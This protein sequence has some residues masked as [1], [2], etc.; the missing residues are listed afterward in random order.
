MA[1]EESFPCDGRRRAAADQKRPGSGPGTG[2]TDMSALVQDRYGRRTPPGRRRLLAALGGV[3]LTAA[4]AFIAWVTLAQGPSLTWEE[5]GYDVISD[6]RAEVT[7]DVSFGGT[8][9][10]T[11][12]FGADRPTA[13]CTVQALN[14][15]RTEVG[16]QDVRVQPGNG[17]R[18]R[19]TVQLETSERATTGLVK[20]CTLVEK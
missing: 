15:L 17:G 13:V 6:G 16:L 2:A 8:G 11:G 20:S 1:D 10:G 18:V 9:T 3:T 4:L 14:E 7:F 12:S 19:A 5:I